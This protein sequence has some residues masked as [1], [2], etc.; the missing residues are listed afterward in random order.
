MKVPIKIHLYF[1]KRY[2]LYFNADYILFFVCRHWEEIED[3]KRITEGMTF[4][5]F[6]LSLSSVQVEKILWKYE[7]KIRANNLFS[8]QLCR[9]NTCICRLIVHTIKK[10]IGKFQ[11]PIW[12]GSPLPVVIDRR[13]KGLKNSKHLIIIVY[14]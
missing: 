10:L 3:Q 13:R 2:L 1:Y 9:Y 14:S 5:D 6:E 4:S 12:W 11:N 8:S 7:L